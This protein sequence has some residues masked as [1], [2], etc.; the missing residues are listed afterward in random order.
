MNFYFG[1]WDDSLET[2]RRAMTYLLST[3]LQQIGIQ[4]HGDDPQIVGLH[5]LAEANSGHLSF[6]SEP[7]YLQALPTTQAAAVLIE[8]RYADQVPEGVIAVVVENPYLSMA[9]ASA[10]FA[11]VPSVEEMEPHIGVRT[12][13]AQSASFGAGVRIGDDV[14]IMPGCY[15]G[16]GVSVGSGSILYANVTIY[17]DC[18]IGMECI[19]HA[20]AVIGADGYGFTSTPEGEIIKIYQN[21][22]VILGD[23]VEV[24]AQTAIDRAVFGATHIGSD[25]KIDNLV[26]IAHNVQIGASCL[27]AGQSGIAGSAVL[28]HGVMMGAQSGVTGHIAIGDGAIIAAKAGVTKSI[29]GGKVYAGFPAVA[30]KQWLRAQAKLQSL[31]KKRSNEENAC[32]SPKP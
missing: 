21:G 30:H 20:G 29:P 16:D 6:L 7:K 5:T 9:R 12:Q 10:L 22:N 25:T 32:P 18:Q 31:A 14:T 27:I 19:I 28:G 17:H 2:Q 13:I 23:R 26:Q 3:L 24:G 8:Q 11:Y 4:Y 15:I 1:I